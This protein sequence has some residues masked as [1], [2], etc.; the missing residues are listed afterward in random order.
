MNRIII[1]DFKSIK[2]IEKLVCKENYN[3]GVFVDFDS[4]NMIDFKIDEYDQ[5]IIFIDDIEILKREYL[6]FQNNKSKIILWVKGKSI[7]P[8]ANFLKNQGYQIIKG[9]KYFN[10]NSGIEK[11]NNLV[12]Q[13]KKNIGIR[14][15]FD[16]AIQLAETLSDDNNIMFIRRLG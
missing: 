4:I 15:N 10:N 1:G 11:A 16:F 13:N 7:K 6:F 12:E 2:K 3:F 8:Y 14:G 5:I 9:L